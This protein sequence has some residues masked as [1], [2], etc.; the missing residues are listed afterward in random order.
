MRA[1]ACPPSIHTDPE[2]GLSSAWSL[3]FEPI[4]RGPS[5]PVQGGC[6]LP[7]RNTVVGKTRGE[8]LSIC[9][10]TAV[11]WLEGLS[12][13][14]VPSFPPRPRRLPFDVG[15][16]ERSVSEGTEFWE[17]VRDDAVDMARP[18][19]TCCARR[20]NAGQDLIPGSIHW[21][22][23]LR[24][25]EQAASALPS[26]AFLFSRQFVHATVLIVPTTDPYCSTNS[27][28]RAT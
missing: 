27:S 16:Q 25:L 3:S 22:P 14:R 17:A 7:S 19:S 12:V 23:R 21:T 15:I 20:P 2:A 9:A 11:V 24:H 26:Q 13:D 28:R 5:L 18:A 6:E 1:T 8:G 10:A 4:S